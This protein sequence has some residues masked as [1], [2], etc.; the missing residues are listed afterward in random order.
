MNR[1]NNSFERNR[2]RQDRGDEEYSREEGHWDYDRTRGHNFHPGRRMENDFDSD[3]GRNR[4]WDSSG[5]T[6]ESYGQGS[7]WRDEHD[8]GQH[9]GS[10]SGNHRHPDSGRMQWRANVRDAYYSRGADI[11]W[12]DDED[13]RYRSLRFDRNPQAQKGGHFGKGP[14]NW[15]RSD[16]RIKE[17]ASESLFRNPRIDASNIELDVKDACVYLRGE[18]DS[19]QMKRAAEECVE[20]LTGVSD[21]RNELR[22]KSPGNVSDF[23]DRNNK[24]ENLS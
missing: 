24:S 7:D 5:T 20:R 14:K 16:E 21:V 2:S 23:G 19:R 12:G 4:G 8:Y 15:R 17:E 13:D 9:S 11:D 1:F 18:I 10:D 3:E 22:V 6:R